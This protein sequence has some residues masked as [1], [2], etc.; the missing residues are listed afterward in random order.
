MTLTAKSPHEASAQL[1]T[2]IMH[3]LK[4]IPS[5]PSRLAQV[6][7][8]NESDCCQHNLTAAQGIGG[9]HMRPVM[10]QACADELQRGERVWQQVV[11]CNAQEAF[12]ADSQGAT[13][14]QALQQIFRVALLLQQAADLHGGT[15]E[16]H[17]TTAF[18][19]ARRL[20]MDVV[21]GV[22]DSDS[23]FGTCA[24]RTPAH[25]T[26]V[27]IWGFRHRVIDCFGLVNSA[28]CLS[29]MHCLAAVFS[30]LLMTASTS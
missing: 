26:L 9:F 14:L 24:R 11:A 1:S 30:Q 28:C 3:R 27:L 18:A 19:A 13:Y 20:S 22:F 10:L 15:G 16:T 5:V 2:C 23:A 7:A 29:Q 12:Q 25:D 21:E 4:P 17:S 8:E 6:D